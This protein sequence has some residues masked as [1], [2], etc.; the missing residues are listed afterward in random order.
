MQR[1]SSLLK[2]EYVQS[3]L[4]IIIVVTAANLHTV[5]GL[6]ILFNDDNARYYSFVNDQY[7]ISDPRSFIGLLFALKWIPVYIFSTYSVEA[8]RLFI[9]FAYMIPVSCLFYYFNRKLLG[10]S[11]WVS[12]GSAVVINII[13]QQFAIPAF[14]DGSYPVPG[15]LVFLTTLIIS[16]LYL[17]S[18][19]TNILFLTIATAGW[20]LVCDLITEMGIFL[21]PVLLY[22]IYTSESDLKRKLYLLVSTFI[23]T[24]Y[25]LYFYYQT[26]GINPTNKP[27]SLTIQDIAY[28]VMKS[29][30]WWLPFERGTT[31]TV[32]VSI[33][34][35]AML[36]F[37][38]SKALKST[39]RNNSTPRAY[40]LYAIWFISCS[41]PFWFLSKYFSPRYFYISHFA[42]T[43]I[44]FIAIYQLFISPRIHRKRIAVLSMLAIF[45]LYGTQRFAINDD[46][47][48]R[49]NK[50]ND[51]I[52]SILSNEAINDTTQI[53]LVN[54]KNGTGG[55]HMWSSGYL[56]YLF[57]KPGIRGVMGNEIN[58][59][60]PFNL[61]HCGYSHTMSCLDTT[62]ELIA[63]K[64]NDDSQIN[65]MMYFL[66]WKNEGNRDSEWSLYRSDDN[67]DLSTISTGAGLDA[68]INTLTELG[69]TPEMVL[70]G[71]HNDTGAVDQLI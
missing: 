40:I 7:K 3:F 6:D 18:N 61:K 57:Q 17:D 14:L 21:Y 63:Y 38:F 69:I 64:K 16:A 58:F 30:E 10:L 70:W 34:I 9:L 47:F 65:R 27:A 71:D 33:L 54:I 8:A 28:R 31:I 48:H 1:I 26:V 60:D 13:P 46:Y 23:I 66:Q 29:F 24:A 4:I 45:I 12:M 42:L 35:V 20:L 41:F 56:Q 49:L 32:I 52:Y 15:M 43:A 11:A 67:N 55:Y 19:R 44:T 37:S 53:A 68:Y 5:F 59:Y 39:N 22:Y 51:F 36:L 50:K 62:K 2:N 25:R